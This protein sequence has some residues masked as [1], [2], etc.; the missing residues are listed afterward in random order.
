[1]LGMSFLNAFDM[2]RKGERLDLRQKF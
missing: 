2:E 1:L